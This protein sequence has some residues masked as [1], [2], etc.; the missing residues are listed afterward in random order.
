MPE[1]PS[2]PLACGS[3]SAVRR[4]A[5][6]TVRGSTTRRRRDAAEDWDLAPVAAPASVGLAG[7]P[8]RATAAR[9]V[10]CRAR[11]VDARTLC[12]Q[13]VRIAT[14]SER[15]LRIR[16]DVRD[17]GVAALGDR[18]GFRQRDG[19]GRLGGLGGGS[20]CR[21]RGR[22]RRGIAVR[23]ASQREARGDENDENE[24]ATHR[25]RAFIARP[26][27]SAN[28]ESSGA[29]RLASLEAGLLDR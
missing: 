11:V 12:I 26:R 9:G 13:A 2:R 6:R 17:V 18:A 8:R 22:A 14:G 3:R 20:G 28:L 10:R 5:L 24:E 25:D 7:A 27:G 21:L 16:G 1:L 4:R 23:R 15:F 19:R 29:L